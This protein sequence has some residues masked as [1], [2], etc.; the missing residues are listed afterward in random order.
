MKHQW[1]IYLGLF[2][3][4]IVL[5]FAPTEVTGI[6]IF[7]EFFIGA[8]QI[9]GSIVRYCY[10]LI[11]QRQHDKSILT[12]WITVVV[13]FSF[14]FYIYYSYIN[15]IPTFLC[16]MKRQA[17]FFAYLLALPIAVW[18]LFNISFLKIKKNGNDETHL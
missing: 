15:H 6:I 14:L 18:Y 9:I 7:L 3:L 11:K 10:Q 5:T 1:L 17:M 12:Y 16:D 13:Y 4:I 8:I 2:V